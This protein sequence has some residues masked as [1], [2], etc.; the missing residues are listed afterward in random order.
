M[1]N[2]DIDQLDVDKLG[3]ESNVLN[4]L[5]N[6][7][8]KLDIGKIDTTT[9]DLKRLSDEVQKEVGKKNVYDNFF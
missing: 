7:V 6:K 2:L 3:K 9:V 4:S 1:V 5:K 8:D